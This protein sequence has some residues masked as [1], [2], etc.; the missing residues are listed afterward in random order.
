MTG[1]FVV[2]SRP[3]VDI[4]ADIKR[5]ITRYPPMMNDRHHV[6]YTVVDGKVTLSG[7]TRTAITQRYLL[8]T[9]HQIDGVTEVEAAGL[10]NDEDIRVGVGQ[11][12]PM[13]V[14]TNVGYGVV[15][16]TGRLPEGTDMT[17]LVAAIEKVPG[18]RL[19]RANF[20]V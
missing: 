8:E 7:Y 15:M 16:L 5:L 1:T 14:Y 6:Q 11:M 19:I 2:A 4:A 9:T 17:A 12:I 3:D 13:G 18:V 20:I 10:F